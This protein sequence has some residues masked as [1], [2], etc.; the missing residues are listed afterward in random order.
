MAVEGEPKCKAV[1]D[2]QFVKQF[3]RNG[4]ECKSGGEY[5]GVGVLSKVLG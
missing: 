2:A 1:I 5:R 4:A 3:G